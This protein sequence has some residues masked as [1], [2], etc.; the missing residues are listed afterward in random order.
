M[1]FAYKSSSNITQFCKSKLK[2]DEIFN[3]SRFTRRQF[4]TDQSRFRNKNEIYNAE[5]RP[6]ITMVESFRQKIKEGYRHPR[7]VPI[8][9]PSKEFDGNVLK[10]FDKV[11]SSQRDHLGRYI[12]AGNNLAS[13]IKHRK[14]PLEPSEIKARTSQD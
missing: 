5:D 11:Y 3:I 8:I 14:V 7:S 9:S 12:E 1:I 2:G 4:F 13:F 6:D 10:V